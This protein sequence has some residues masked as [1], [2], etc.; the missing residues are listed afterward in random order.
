MQPGAPDPQ[1]KLAVNATYPDAEPVTA[2][3]PELL[4]AFPVLP[5]DV[6]YRVVGRTLIVIDV[7]SR[8]I[9]DIAR[10]ILPPAS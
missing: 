5:G 6:A 4:A 7:K 8:L 3:P 2:L 9:V 10:R 1:M